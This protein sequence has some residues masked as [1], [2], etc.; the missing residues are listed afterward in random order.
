MFLR[1]PAPQLHTTASRQIVPSTCMKWTSACEGQLIAVCSLVQTSF[2]SP[3]LLASITRAG[4][5]HVSLFLLCALQLVM[6]GRYY[7]ISPDEYIFA[8]LNIYL[9]GVQ[10]ASSRQ[11]LSQG[12][13]YP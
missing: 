12:L 10:A 9:V 13:T 4:L 11:A 3:A 1:R 2:A 6:G 5:T 7:S 8:A